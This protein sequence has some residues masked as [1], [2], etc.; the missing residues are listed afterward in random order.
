MV[1][2]ILND[3]DFS[4]FKDSGNPECFKL[5]LNLVTS[6]IPG[7]KLPTAEYLIVL[8]CALKITYVVFHVFVVVNKPIY[9]RYR[10][11]IVTSPYNLPRMF[12]RIFFKS[13]PMFCSHLKRHLFIV[14]KS[15][16]LYACNNFITSV[17][18]SSQF[19]TKRLQYL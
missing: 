17:I 12:S 11:E 2:K 4:F 3:Q 13:L 18:T 10:W 5:I 7:S 19:R 1:W 6:I 14:L 8:D 16:L 15:S 9:L